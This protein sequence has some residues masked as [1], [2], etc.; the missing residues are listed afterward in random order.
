M[1]HVPMAIYQQPDPS[2]RRRVL[3]I[4]I[5]SVVL[6]A[7]TWIV[8][9][10]WLDSLRAMTSREAQSRLVLGLRVVGIALGTTVV[11]LGAYAVRLGRRTR[12]NARFPP[13]GVGVMRRTAVLEG[14]EARARGRLLI[15]LGIALVT[16]GG[17]V[18]LTVNWVAAML[19]R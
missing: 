16:V 12:I 13:P 9:E 14:A 17:L 18:A 7:L 4:V 5:G 15:G 3:L 6:C 8:T 1:Q 19:G 11:A 2:V 10:R